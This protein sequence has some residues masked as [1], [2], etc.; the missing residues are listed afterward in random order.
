MS[1]C[2]TLTQAE[3]DFIHH[4]RYESLHLTAGPAG[5]WLHANGIYS[6]SMIPF[7]YVNQESNPRWLDRLTEDP[8]PPF[9]PAWSSREEFEAKAAQIVEAYPILK[10]LPSALPGFN[11]NYTTTF[12]KVSF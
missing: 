3:S 2:L 5:D 1:E 9:K 8:F 10:K 7:L 6:S 12:E 11:P 4:Y